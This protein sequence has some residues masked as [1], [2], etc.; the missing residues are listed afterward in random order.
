MT[1]SLSARIAGWLP[2]PLWVSIALAIMLRLAAAAYIGNT[3]EPLPGTY[4][5]VSYD[6]LAQRV[7][8]GYGFSFD[9]ASWPMTAAGAPTAHWSFLYTGFLAALYRVLGHEPLAARLLQ[10]VA[11]GVLLPWGLC[12]L[13]E[14]ALTRRVG[15]RVALSRRVGEWAAL[16]SAVYIYFVYYSATIMTEMFTIV[17]LV[18]LL[19]LAIDIAER[20]SWTRWLAFGALTA[21][22]AML[23]QVSLLA[24][25]VIGLWILWQRWQAG[26][27]QA[28]AMAAAVAGQ[29]GKTAVG[30]PGE[31]AVGQ[32]SEPGPAQPGRLSGA[33]P[34]GGIAAAVAGMALAAGITILLILPITIRNYEVFHRLVPINTNAGY[35]FFWANH[36][37]HG[38]DFQGIFPAVWPTYQEL[39]P[40]QLRGLDEAALNDA[41]MARG[42]GFV[43]ADPARYAI[44][45]ISRLEDY[46]RFWPSRDS[47]LVSNVSRVLSFALLLPLALYGLVLSRPWRG[48]CL[49]L[50]LFIGTYA[51]VHLLSWAL[52]RYRLPIDAVLLVFAGLAL[53]RI[54]LNWR[55]ARTA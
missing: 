23:R 20:P 9:R 11:I 47:S 31:P 10:A 21:I 5:Q 54:T 27:W 4:D 52:V 15:E 8:G 48:T 29:P 25:P 7:A 51:A 36:P 1:N 12:R 24:V 6:A 32:P 40:Q 33:E 26:H 39:I 38:T 28:R 42:V 37:I 50:Y 46:F 13:G 30:Q 14:R 45:S 22:A 44:L 3:V 17:A 53:E 49:P 19:G 18:W 34:A 2:P 41:L 35:A 16:L 43:T 55:G